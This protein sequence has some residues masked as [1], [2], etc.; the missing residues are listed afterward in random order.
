MIDH[1]VKAMHALEQISIHLDWTAYVN[2]LN[3][4]SDDQQRSTKLRLLKSRQM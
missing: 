4:E 2:K 3:W 1:L